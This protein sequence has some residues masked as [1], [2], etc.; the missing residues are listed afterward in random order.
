MKKTFYHSN[1]LFT[2][3]ICSIIALSSC[4]THRQVACAEIESSNQFVKHDYR[5]KVRLQKS[6]KDLSRKISTRKIEMASKKQRGQNSTID[7]QVAISVR[8][9]GDSLLK[10]IKPGQIEIRQMPDAYLLASTTS[11]NAYL[12]LEKAVDPEKIDFQA[13][14]RDVEQ[15]SD[16][17][18]RELRQ[19]NRKFRQEY[20]SG[21]SHTPASGTQDEYE[22]PA[23]GFA[24]A[25]LVLGILG[26]GSLP[27]AASLLAIIF[28]AVALKR[29]RR[30]P[31]QEGRGMAVAG[32]ILGILGIFVAFI[33]LVLGIVAFAVG[34]ILSLLFFWA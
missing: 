25:S 21:F 32:I 3:T 33:V 8:E 12:E 16:M 10:S 27:F 4:S 6:G 14:T 15:I 9:P 19:F 18:A 28:G 31:G 7:Q 2:L 29:I 11:G 17:S 24:I 23:I 34:G 26:L 30:N 20:K 5:K 1:M 13:G 22:K